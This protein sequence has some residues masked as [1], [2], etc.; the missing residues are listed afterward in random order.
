MKCKICNLN[1]LVSQGNTWWEEYTPG[2]YNYDIII[3][4]NI[5]GQCN[6]PIWTAYKPWYDGDTYGLSLSQYF[7]KLGFIK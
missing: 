2:E 4:A 5:C 1:N 3:I 7:K 6:V